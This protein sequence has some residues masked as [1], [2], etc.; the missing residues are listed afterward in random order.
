MI[1]IL[2]IVITIIIIRINNIK[3]AY[4]N[5]Y[6]KLSQIA[7]LENIKIY[8]KNKT[9]DFE[10]NYNNKIYLIKMIYHPSR[11]E[12]N[13]NAKDYWQ[14]NRGTVSSRTS[15]EQMKGVYDLINFDLKNNNYP[16]NTVK[17]YVIYPDSVSLLKVINECE[18]KFITPQIDIYGCKMNRFIDLEEKINEI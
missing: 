8:K 2:L 13:V 16:K 12:I 3:K 18:M 15:G 17:L 6:L 14:I 5:L 10:M 1:L 7:G 11:A 9:F 4:N